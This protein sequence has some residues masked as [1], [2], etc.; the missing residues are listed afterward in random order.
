MTATAQS[1]Q[2]WLTARPADDDIAHVPRV[3]PHVD[4]VVVVDEISLEG[5]LVERP[6]QARRIA[7]Q[8]VDD[9]GPPACKRWMIARSRALRS[10]SPVL[11]SVPPHTAR[12]IFPAGS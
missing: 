5:R 10:C 11:Q 3:C 8:A 2:H 7:L 1:Q 9:N 6:Q 4:A 12:L